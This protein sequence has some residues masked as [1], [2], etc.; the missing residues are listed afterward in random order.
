MLE[1][2]MAAGAA[3]LIAWLAP[4]QA[5]AQ[6]GAVPEPAIATYVAEHAVAGPGELRPVM[7][8]GEP[9]GWILPADIPE[10]FR[11]EAR[12]EKLQPRFQ[13][14]L[15]QIGIELSID[16]RDAITDCRGTYGHVALAPQFC[17]VLRR[18]GKF[19]HALTLDGKPAPGTASLTIQFSVGGEGAE[20]GLPPAPPAPMGWPVTHARGI[21]TMTR[22]PEW[23][24]FSKVRDGRQSAIAL[25]LESGTVLSCKLLRSSGDAGLDAA[26]CDAARTGAYAIEPAQT[27]AQ[28]P[29][30]VRWN[31]DGAQAML[32]IRESYQR[33]TP[34]SAGELVVRGAAGSPAEAWLT[35][36][37]S[38]AVTDCRISLSA[39][40]DAADVALCAAMRGARFNPASDVFGL[41]MESRYLAK[42]RFE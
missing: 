22:Q 35:L 11:T 4:V 24:R 27:Y 12:G 14:I 34:A 10:R 1:L 5:Q 30:L 29:M 26:S 3:A 41:P 40:G 15:G 7:A 8:V 39:G 9:R 31:R 25:L 20:I 38:G 21:A 42:V 33:P 19:R 16:D 32:P 37:Q 23:R 18:R 6:A 36:S 28:L 2:R 17:E 13:H